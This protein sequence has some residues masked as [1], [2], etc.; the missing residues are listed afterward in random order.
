[1]DHWKDIDL[2]DGTL[3]V[4]RG[5]HRVRSC[6]QPADTHLMRKTIIMT[7]AAALTAGCGGGDSAEA[8][9][10]ATES[11]TSAAALESATAAAP[12]TTAQAMD[13]ATALATLKDAGLPITDSA[14]ITETNDANDLIGRPGQYVS[15]VAFAD[16]RLGVPIDPAEPGNEGGGSIEVFADDAEAQARSDYIQ[17]TLQSLGPIAGTE[18]HYL[19]G[20]ILV[21]VTG[22]LPPSV[23]AEYGA[24]VADLS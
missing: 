5:I 21:R 18:Y 13:A 11:S 6:R 10:R 14:V 22:E 7:I 17:E 23:A 15:K 1:L 2:L 8:T 9:A 12:S 19:A 3:T 24:A 20:P 16:S 4:R